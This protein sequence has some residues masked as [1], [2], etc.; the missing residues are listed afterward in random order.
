MATE[1]EE[2]DYL[3]LPDLRADS[4]EEDLGLLIPAM[5]KALSEGQNRRMAT[6][7]LGRPRKAPTG[8]LTVA[9]SIVIICIYRTSW[10]L[11]NLPGNALSQLARQ[12]WSEISVQRSS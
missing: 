10:P 5:K 3:F 9:T 4:G 12:C 2:G 7:R 1:V 11:A 6:M 8:C